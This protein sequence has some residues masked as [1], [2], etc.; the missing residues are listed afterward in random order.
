MEVSGQRHVPAALPPGRNP[1][2]YRKLGGVEDPSG[3]VRKISPPPGFD[4]RNVQPSDAG[5]IQEYCQVTHVLSCV[6]LVVPPPCDVST[7]S[8]VPLQYVDSPRY[9]THYLFVET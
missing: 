9:L 8:E 1:I 4:Q 6:W 7:V 5:H 2:L 3:W